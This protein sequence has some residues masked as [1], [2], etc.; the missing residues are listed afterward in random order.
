[1]IVDVCATAL[2]HMGV[3]IR[4]EWNLDARLT[5]LPQ[6]PAVYGTNLIFNGDAEFNSGTNNY[7]IRDDSQNIDRGIAWW[8]DAAP[9]TLGQYGS[10]PN[11]PA[12]LAGGGNNFFLGGLGAT[13]V[14]SQKIDLTHLA[15]DMDGPGVNYS[16]TGS[17]GGRGTET[18]SASLQARFLN[19]TG[20]VLQTCM[21][22]GVTSL[23]R[24]N[25]TG[26]L[27]RGTNGTLPAG[28]R[29]VEFVLTA[30][31]TSTTNDASADNLS[32]VL[33]PAP[34][35]AASP[36]PGSNGWEIGVPL[37]LT[38][39][40]YDLWRSADLQSWTNVTEPVSG[41]GSRLQLLDTNPPPAGA[42]YRTGVRSPA[43]R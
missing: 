27:P 2:H 38:N 12:S 21:I 7:Y 39:R 9:M 23:E 26:L 24:A 3:D 40:V 11:F 4:P 15:A 1:M 19:G 14:I 43:P 41:N 18:D 10:H 20:A 36:Q 6:P 29:L 5:G 31:A 30:T 8:F 33:T 37:S 25:A 28:T 32:F 35:L 17:F 34:F 22:G 13:S 16:L 42:F